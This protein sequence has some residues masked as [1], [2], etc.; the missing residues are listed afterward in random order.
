M[1]FPAARSILR[2]HRILAA[3]RSQ[4]DGKSAYALLNQNNT[5]AKI[6]LT[7]KPPK[8]GE[9]IRVGNAP[10]SI[11][12]GPDGKRLPTSATRVAVSPR[13]RTSKS[14]QPALKS[15][16]TRLLAHAITGTVSVVDL[17]SMKVTA[18][19]ST[20]LHPTG[21]A[22]MGPST[23][24]SPILIA[25]PSRSSTRSHQRSG[26]G[27]STLDCRSA[28]LAKAKRP[29]EPRR[30]PSP[31]MRKEGCCLRRALQRQCNWGDQP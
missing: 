1:Q 24:W 12:I 13:M 7:A 15:L 8:Q 28:C 2:A 10:H 26:I 29:M 9:Q 22:F 20:G 19:I 23:C 17:R 14:G 18:T 3:S 27:Q 16:P 25:T 6:D 5:L 21:M 11:V 4:R 31:S 30:T